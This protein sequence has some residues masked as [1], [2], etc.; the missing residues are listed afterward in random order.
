MLAFMTDSTPVDP[1][2][3][4]RTADRMFRQALAARAESAEVQGLKQ[5]IEE[6]RALV[7]MLRAG[8]RLRDQLLQEQATRVREETLRADRAQDE[9]Q[10][11]T[12]SEAS[13]ARK[14]HPVLGRLSRRVAMPIRGTRRIIG[15]MA[16]K[17][18]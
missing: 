10:A 4:L 12:S 3:D 14:G 5:E 8:I 11:A 9:L 6:Y 7:T 13:T 1:H 18:R 15:T 2:T 17:N 16:G